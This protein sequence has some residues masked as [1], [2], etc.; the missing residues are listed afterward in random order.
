MSSQVWSMPSYWCNRG[1]NRRHNVRWF[2]GHSWYGELIPD[3][4]APAMDFWTIQSWWMARRMHP[5]RTTRHPRTRLYRSFACS[6]ATQWRQKREL[7]RTLGVARNF[8][9]FLSLLQGTR[10]DSS[11]KHSC[12]MLLH[13][14]CRRWNRTTS[15]AGAPTNLWANRITA[16]NISL[17]NFYSILHQITI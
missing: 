17:K 9:I 2:R 12:E 6:R 1:E 13:R 16:I 7:H 15:Y 4:L 8:G 5:R 11:S 3:R 10:V 14:Y